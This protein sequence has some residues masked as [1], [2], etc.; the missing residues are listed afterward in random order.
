MWDHTHGQNWL[1]LLFRLLPVLIS[2]SSDGSWVPPKP[3][4][5]T[6]KT[7]CKIGRDNRAPLFDFGAGCRQDTN[8]KQTRPLIRRRSP[9]RVFG[10]L[11]RRGNIQSDQEC[12][13][14]QQDKEQVFRARIF[15]RPTSLCRIIC[16][17]RSLFLRKALL[18]Q[19]PTT[20]YVPY[21]L[22]LIIVASPRGG[23]VLKWRRPVEVLAAHPIKGVE[24]TSL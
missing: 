23:N 16:R 21:Y 4:F 9:R 24:T 20:T 1:R 10:S 19:R 15:P 14:V 12:G 2:S 22:C 17:Y 3:D 11:W 6:C 18:W 13:T 7:S 5:G 8:A